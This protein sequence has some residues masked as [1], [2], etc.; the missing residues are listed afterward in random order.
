M[1]DE[2]LNEHLFFSMNHARAVVA[3][4]V[5]DF[6]TARPHSAIGYMT[7]AAYAATLNPQ[8]APALRH[9][10]K[11]RADARCYRRAHAQFSTPDSSDPWMNK[12]GHVSRYNATIDSPEALSLQTGTHNHHLVWPNIRGGGGWIRTSVGLP[13]RIYSPLHLT[14]LPPLRGSLRARR[15]PERMGAGLG[16]RARRVNSKRRRAGIAQ[17][18]ARAMSPGGTGRGAAWR[19]SR[20]GRSSGSGSGREATGTVW[21]F[22]LHAVRDALLNPARERRRLVVTRNAAERLADAIA[23]SGMRP[24]D[25]RPAPVRRAARS[26]VGAP[27]RGARG[28]AA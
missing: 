4:W 20:P 25:R 18:G 8:R 24:R 19:G 16:Q 14:A 12:G 22:G 9:L 11:L 2:C 15:S 21:L 28:R 17:A 5:E 3:G 1:R 7:P 6:N 10:G 27:G 23:A 13:R 26:A